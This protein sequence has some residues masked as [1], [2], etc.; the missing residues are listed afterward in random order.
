MIGWLLADKQ[1]LIVLYFESETVLKFYN[2]EDW[3]TRLE[4]HLTI[5][6]LIL[7]D[8]FFTYMHGMFKSISFFVFFRDF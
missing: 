5:E 2:L 8:F 7:A 1:P 6:F 4:K 3:S